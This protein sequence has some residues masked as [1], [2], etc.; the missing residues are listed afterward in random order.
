[1]S[2]PGRPHAAPARGRRSLA[3]RRIDDVAQ[4]S[5][6]KPCFVGVLAAACVF[7]CAC[8]HPLIDAII[9]RAEPEKV[10]RE[11]SDIVRVRVM[12]TAAETVGTSDESDCGYRTQSVVLESFRGAADAYEFLSP[13]PLENGREY[14]V[15][16]RDFSHF[17]IDDTTSAFMRCRAR[18]PRHAWRSAPVVRVDGEDWVAVSESRM[19][20]H[21][22]AQTAEHGRVSWPD[23]RGLIARL[24]AVPAGCTLG[25]A[26]TYCYDRE[27]CVDTKSITCVTGTAGCFFEGRW[28]QDCSA[29]LEDG[30]PR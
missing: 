18:L 19:F 27:D 23:A 1:M 4:P 28:V 29:I 26:T 20:P 5:R 13:T 30:S 8:T 10:F 6:V 9:L 7:A 14:L 12:S 21:F 22:I 17:T 2:G 11:A 15:A 25:A 24:I 16:G 3:T